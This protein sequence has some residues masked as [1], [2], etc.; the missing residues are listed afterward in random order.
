MLQLHTVVE[1][2]LTPLHTGRISAL[3]VGRA[4]I[5]FTWTGPD[6][7]DVPLD[8]SRSVAYDLAPGRYTVTAVDA[9][10]AVAEAHI[11]I[12][13][14]TLDAVVVSGYETT[15]TT[16]SSSSDGQVVATGHNLSSQ[17]RFLWSNGAVTPSA[18]LSGVR[19][20]TYFVSPYPEEGERVT[21]VQTC[22]PAQVRVCPF[23]EET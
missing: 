13:R 2:P 6:G 20:G 16:S 10:E 11:T 12:L 22:P 23:R 8:S 5:L 1:Q 3:P 14:S 7:M 4:P 21:F 18:R 15:G 19:E 9:S 17:K